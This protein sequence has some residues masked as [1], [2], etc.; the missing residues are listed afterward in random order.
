[1]KLYDLVLLEEDVVIGRGIGFA[2][3]DAEEAAKRVFSSALLE[4]ATGLA[5]RYWPD[6]APLSKPEPEPETTPAA[7]KK[8]KGGK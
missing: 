6:A 8:A 3:E 1:M 7:K 4:R 5:S 2:G